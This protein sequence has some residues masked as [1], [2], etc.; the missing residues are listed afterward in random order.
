[1]R[2]YRKL[3]I[4]CSLILSFALVPLNILANEKEELDAV[5]KIEEQRRMDRVMN[6]SDSSQWLGIVEE[7]VPLNNEI[8][9]Y[10]NCVDC[11]LLTK[12]VCAAE[13]ILV[14]E[15]YHNTFL[16]GL[17]TDCYAYYFESHGAAMCPG[18]WK[19]VEQ[20]GRHAC[21]ERHKKCSKGDYDVCIMDIS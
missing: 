6:S 21:W 16:L 17:P 14:D 12:N 13:A 3:L 2:K 5:F 18:C 15:G 10:P 11:S 1:M 7:N 19:V 9:V 8:S 20:Y 4:I